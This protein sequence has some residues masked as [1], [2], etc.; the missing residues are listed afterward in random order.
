MYSATRCVIINEEVLYIKQGVC[1]GIC[2]NVCSHYATAFLVFL[3]FTGRNRGSATSSMP[4]LI[5]AS[6]APSVAIQRPGGMNHHQ[7]PPPNA[8]ACCAQYSIP[9]QLGIVPSPNPRNSS[10]AQARMIKMV[11]LTKPATTRLISLGKISKK[12]MRQAFSP[13]TRDAVTNSRFRKD[14]VCERR[15]RACQ[16]QL[17]IKI[18]IEIVNGPRGK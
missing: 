14:N 5:S 16:A 8:P 18:T 6:P 9:P 13:P 11:V 15:T 17:V 12:I 7:S 3:F 4:K 2:A 10:A 1:V